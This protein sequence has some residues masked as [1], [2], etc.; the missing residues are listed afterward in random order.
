MSLDI[1]ITNLKSN[2]RFV[3]TGFS[4]FMMGYF[5]IDKGIN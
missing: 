4:F 5:F 1:F 2:N 3:K